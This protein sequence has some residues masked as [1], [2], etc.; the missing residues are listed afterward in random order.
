MQTHHT[1]QL[2]RTES[3]QGAPD[4]HRRSSSEEPRPVMRPYASPVQHGSP[5]RPHAVHTPSRHIA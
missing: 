4:Q 2:D 1:T 3:G 5:G